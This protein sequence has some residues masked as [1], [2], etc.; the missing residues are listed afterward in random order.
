MAV[1]E[2]LKFADTATNILSQSAYDADAQRNDGASGIA[3]SPL[4]NKTMKQTTT[5]ASGLSQ[6]IADNQADDIT[7]DL[8]PSEYSDA[9]VEALSNADFTTQPQFDNSQ[10]IATTEFVNRARESYVE[11]ID[12]SSSSLLNESHIG[13]FIYATTSSINIGLPSA[14]DVPFGSKLTLYANGQT[15]IVIDTQSPDVINNRLSGEV[16]SISLRPFDNITFTKTVDNTWFVDYGSGSL[17]ASSSFESSIPSSASGY[18]YLPNGRLVQY[19]SGTTDVTGYVTLTF[20]IPFPST[21]QNMIVSISDAVQ[22]AVITG[23]ARISTTQCTLW[24]LHSTTGAPANNIFVH[25]YT[26]G[27]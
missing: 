9:F 21:S 6:F 8:T 2:I 17:V 26:I 16:T 22:A 19:G 27:N 7:D 14:D 5:V 3:R 1:N 15:N 13:C 23:G 18:F 10:K 24:A 11:T 4:N 20:P 12:I 25:Y